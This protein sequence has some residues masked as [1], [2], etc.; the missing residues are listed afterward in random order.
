[1]SPWVK[2]DEAFW[3]N[4]K[5]RRAWKAGRSPLGLYLLGLCYA[6]DQLTDGLIDPEWIDDQVPNGRER[7]HL[8]A[9]L[10]DLALW[11]PK[12]GGFQVK[13]YF[14]YNPS[15]ADVLAKRKADSERKRSGFRTESNWNPD[16]IQTSV[17]DPNPKEK[18]IPK[19]RERR[20]GRRIGG[21]SHD[22]ANEA[23]LSWAAIKAERQR[24]H[25]GEQDDG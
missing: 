15:R 23:G 20:S 21:P 6:N 18:E 9:V 19:E 1:M 11:E 25:L 14:D 8:I 12:S 24:P 7:A 4:R 10:V 5:I 3:R 22:E 2:L 17:P 13:D 16:G